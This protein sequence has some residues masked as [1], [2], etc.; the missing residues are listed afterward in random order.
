MLLGLVDEAVK[1]VVDLLAYV[2][3]QAEEF[4]V[5]AVQYGL[6]EVALARILAV[7]QVEELHEKALIDVLL[8]RVG[9]KVGRLEKA[10]EELVDDLQVRPRRLQARLVLLRIELGAARIR[11]RRQ[12]AKHV[13]REHAHDLVVRLV[14]EYA[15]IARYVLDELVERLPLHLL[16]LQ[17]AERVAREVEHHRA[18][19]DLL[20][21]QAFAFVRVCLCTQITADLHCNT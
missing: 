9:L 19:L 17:V 5:D 8:G 15:P 20:D 11:A 14:G 2:G 21:E 18:L 7:E 1:R 16:V 12:S 10:Q 6:E 13:R 4:A 3:A